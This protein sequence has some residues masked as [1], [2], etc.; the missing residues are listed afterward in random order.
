MQ[1]PNLLHKSVAEIAEKQLKCSL[2][3][4]LKMQVLSSCLHALAA[5]RS[6]V[7][8]GINV[9]FKDPRSLPLKAYMPLPSPLLQRSAFESTGNLMFMHPFHLVFILCA[10]PVSPADTHL[11]RG[12]NPLTVTARRYVGA[13]S[14]LWCSGLGSRSGGGTPR[15]SGSLCRRAIPPEPRPP[16]G[17]AGSPF[18]APAFL[19]ALRRLLLRPRWEPVG[20]GLWLVT[21]WIALH[22]V[23]HPGWSWEEVS[24]VPPLH[25]H[26]GP[27][28]TPLNTR[29]CVQLFRGEMG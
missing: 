16:P 6:H 12:Q 1:D 25:H 11:P 20:R 8:R 22:L 26:P 7:G 15:S 17:G 4:C 18:P 29:V 21:R 19:P 2:D 24:I 27:P 9:V 10:D 14:W 3:L 5:P 23:A 13:S 28:H